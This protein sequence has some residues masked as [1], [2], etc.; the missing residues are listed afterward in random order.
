[1]QVNHKQ[2]VIPPKL[3]VLGYPSIQCSFP[4]I[5]PCAHHIIGPKGLSNEN[6]QRE[7]AINSFILSVLFTSSFC[8]PCFICSHRS[9]IRDTTKWKIFCSDVNYLFV[10]SWNCLSLKCFDMYWWIE[11][12]CLWLLNAKFGNHIKT[13]LEQLTTPKT[14]CAPEQ[15]HLM[16][17]FKKWY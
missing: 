2:N 12:K 6:K 14:I 4:Y 10:A 16:H 5:N 15:D 17:S 13:E 8:S 1:M 11:R 7:N 9:I 3:Q